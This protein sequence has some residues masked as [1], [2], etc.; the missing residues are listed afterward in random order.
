MLYARAPFPHFTHSLGVLTPW[1]CTSRFMVVTFYW[2][3]T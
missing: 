2:P 3:G 1:I